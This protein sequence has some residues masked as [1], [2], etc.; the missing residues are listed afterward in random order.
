M[1]RLAGSGVGAASGGSGARRALGRVLCA[2]GVLGEAELDAAL[3]EQRRSS[4][5]LGQVLVARGLADDVAIARALAE[6]RGLAFVD[7]GSDRPDAALA[8]PRDAGT[9]AEAGFIPWRAEGGAVVFVTSDP[10]AAGA[11]LE[12]LSDPPAEAR[13]AVAPRAEIEAAIGETLRG[14]LTRR[15]ALRTPA[16]YSVRDLHHA[17]F[18]VAGVVVA[19]AAAVA[20]GGAP[21]VAAGLLCLVLI[22]AATSLLRLS[23]LLASPA[24]SEQPD[25]V[26]DG[27]IDLAQHRPLPSVSVLVPLY[28]EAA[29]I[30]EI[31]RALARLDYPRG[32][33]EVLLLLEETD[34][35]TRAAV[36]AARLPGW[37][38]PMVVPDGRPRT[39]PRAM[40]YALDFCQGEIVGIF[41]AED[42]PAPDQLSRV[43]E[44]F[45][46]APPEIGAV[47]CQLTY[48]NAR[49]NWITRCFQIEYALWFTVLLR[50]FERL[51]LP[52]P[53][54]GTSVYM[55]RSVLKALGGWDAQNVTEDA[56]L[57]MRLAR[58]GYRCRVLSVA[59]EEEAACRPGA[60]VRQRSRWLKG[61]L[62]TLIG[63]MRAPARL[64]RDLG[65]AGFFGLGVLFLGAV[66]TFLAMPL[67]WV[68]LIGALAGLP[69]PMGAGLPP[70]LAWVA[71][72]SFAAGQVVILAA[73]WIAMRRKGQAD[74]LL[75]LPLAPVYWTLGSIAAWKA[76]TELV[77]APFYWD[78]TTHGVSK[79]APGQVVI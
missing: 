77:F 1:S 47:Q 46:A 13:F 64:W 49:E 3:E 35:E 41:D 40:N 31:A 70:E 51:G 29:M 33:L 59:T 69:S 22:D 60:W 55:R 37:I 15:A 5:R 26:P 8:D 28:R 62:M 58:E 57:G 11:A 61:Y 67:F 18:V 30:P 24:R 65:P 39:K 44:T 78:K 19:A 7:L 9:Y 6:Q 79:L 75:W 20:L 74:L 14:P 73:A 38:R 54:G 63:H 36:A 45:R 43:A 23:A 76:M 72:A 66:A 2:Q 71:A 25:A 53:L 4:V 17:R 42:R 48:Y 21:A 52:I 10:D 32:R 56:D 34:R 16:H 12:Q 27:A 68:A 50:G